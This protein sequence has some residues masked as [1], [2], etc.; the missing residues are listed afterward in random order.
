MWIWDGTDRQEDDFEAAFAEVIRRSMISSNPQIT[1]DMRSFVAGFSVALTGR[2]SDEL[3]AP[4]PLIQGGFTPSDGERDLMCESVQ[5]SG[6][7]LIH[8]CF[9]SHGPYTP[10]GLIVVV[11]NDG[12]R[13]RLHSRC[14]IV[15]E[16]ED[17]LLGLW[18][19]EDEP[20]QNCHFIFRR[21]KKLLRKNG[22]RTEIG[23]SKMLQ[24]AS[25]VE[26][27]IQSGAIGDVES[28]PLKFFHQGLKIRVHTSP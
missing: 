6:R 16:N 27:L 17:S 11:F 18:G 2:P 22:H 20:D 19:V 15:F 24:A 7:D 12:N 9:R 5:R 3:N 14:G 1:A 13:I 23:S 28:E 25:R 21:G 26:D 4:E 8:I 10:T